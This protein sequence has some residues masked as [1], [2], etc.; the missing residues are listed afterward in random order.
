MG[1]SY[2]LGKLREWIEFAADRIAHAG[3][4]RVLV[5]GLA[6]VGLPDPPEGKTKSQLAASSVAATP[7]ECLPEIAQRILDRDAEPALRNAL[8]D[9]LWAAEPVP[10][11][12]KRLRREIARDLDLEPYLPGYPHFKAMLHELWDLSAD[13]FG[14]FFGNDTS[15]GGQIDQHV[16]RNPGDW[17]AEDLFQ[18]LGAF[19]ALNKRFARFLEGL[20][21]GEVLLDESAQRATVESRRSW[22]LSPRA[23][24]ATGC[25]SPSSPAPGVRASEALGVHVEDLT[26]TADDEHVTVYGKRGRS[27]TILLDDANP[28]GGVLNPH[29]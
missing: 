1:N 14:S 28:R 24:C 23:T 25:C 17:T 2:D 13:D 19:D 10:D 18:N 29:H 16:R 6:S 8:Q 27:R 15:L 22:P 11:I 3:P 20:V 5:A 12:P 26:L 4:T 7:D 9:L 21:S